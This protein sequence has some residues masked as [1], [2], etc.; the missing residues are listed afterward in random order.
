NTGIPGDFHLFGEWLKQKYADSQEYLTEEEEI[1]RI[2]VDVMTSYLIGGLTG[3][4]ET[5]LKLAYQ[6]LPIVSLGD[7]GIIKAVEHHQ[8]P[9][10]KM[11]ADSLIMERTTCM[12]SIKRMVK[13]GLLTEETD[14]KDRRMKRVR[15][16]PKGREMSMLLNKKM[17]ALSTLLVGNLDELE[18]KSLIPILKKLNKFHEFLYREKSREEVKE[19]YYL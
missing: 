1:N 16:T 3:Y 15:L 18:K 19:R 9:T 11:I 2:G 7:F 17:S 14:S 12:E 8:N 4:L 6:D 13:E 10:K 5:W